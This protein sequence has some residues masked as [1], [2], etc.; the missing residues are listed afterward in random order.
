MIFE[1]GL[2]TCFVQDCRVSNCRTNNRIL[3]Q[4][5]FLNKAYSN[6][7][8][9]LIMHGRGWYKREDHEFCDSN[10]VCQ[11]FVTLEFSDR[12]EIEISRTMIHHGFVSRMNS[13]EKF[14]N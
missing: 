6:A 13:D 11:S 8:G 12:R 2:T 10:F 9:E 4:P 3:H 14:T 7:K 5:P 1:S